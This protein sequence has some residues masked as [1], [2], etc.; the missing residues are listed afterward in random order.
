MA[1]GDK[2][3][4]RAKWGPGY[5]EEWV[6]T[7]AVYNEAPIYHIAPDTDN[8]VSNGLLATDGSI[9]HSIAE[10]ETHL[11][12]YE[13]WFGDGGQTLTPFQPD[14]GN[15]DWG[16][17]MEV[18]QTTD[19][20]VIPGMA[21]YDLHRLMVTDTEH[22]DV[23]RI[24]IAFGADPNAAVLANEY[25][26]VM[27]IAGSATVNGGPIDVQGKRHLSGTQAW[28]RVWNANNTGTIDLFVGL[29]EYEG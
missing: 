20:P 26:E 8:L 9:G 21:Y 25:T 4:I 17:W 5:V 16:D 19:T 27:Y 28:V 11:H 2:R 23:Y 7:G 6:D 12:S 3:Y 14:S 10:I 15:D 13:R 29:H 22:T 24:Q 18:L 1:A